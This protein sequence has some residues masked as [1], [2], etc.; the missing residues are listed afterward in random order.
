MTARILFLCA[1]GSSRALLA[2]SLLYAQNTSPWETWSTPA[3]PAQDEQ[4]KKLVERVLQEQGI[5]LLP[6]DRLIVPAFGMHRDQ[7]IILCSGSVDI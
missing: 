6:A 7:G 5:A 4:G 2:A 3:Q 1:Q